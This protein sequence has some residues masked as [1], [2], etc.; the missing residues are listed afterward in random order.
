VHGADAGQ[1]LEIESANDT[2][3]VR[4]V[5]YE[6]L[7]LTDFRFS[8]PF[9]ENVLSPAVIATDSPLH[10]VYMERA[11]GAEFLLPPLTLSF[12]VFICCLQSN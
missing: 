1:G 7:K 3:Q 5:R 6:A 2:G 4:T 11:G 8:V 9:A 10:F 12:F